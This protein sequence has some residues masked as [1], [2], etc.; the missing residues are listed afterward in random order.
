MLCVNIASKDTSQHISQISEVNSL[1]EFVL[2]SSWV[3]SIREIKYQCSSPDFSVT[4]YFVSGVVL[5]RHIF[6][7][8]STFSQSS[9]VSRGLKLHTHTRQRLILTGF[10]RRD[11]LLRATAQVVDG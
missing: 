8:G 7:L 6:V 9:L 1:E 5:V 3:F 4:G 10:Q 2:Y 11:A